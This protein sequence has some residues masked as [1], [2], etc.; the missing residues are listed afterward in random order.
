MNGD[1]DKFIFAFLK[2]GGKFDKT[3]Q[4]DDI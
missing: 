3:E 1:L 4:N 2:T